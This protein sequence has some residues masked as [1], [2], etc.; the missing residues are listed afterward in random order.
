MIPLSSWVFF[1]GLL[2][3]LAAESELKRTSH[4]V[5]TS[6]TGRAFFTLLI[7]LHLP[8]MIM[9]Y[10]FYADWLFHYTLDATQLPSAI[11]IFFVFCSA[12]VGL[13]GFGLGTQWVRY[14][15]KG[16][17][18]TALAAVV[19]LNVVLGMVLRKRWMSVATTLSFSK[20][21]GIL[22]IFKT[23]LAIYLLIYFIMMA[24]Q[25]GWIILRVTKQ[26]TA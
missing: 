16:H 3:S 20:H 25:L 5:L 2:A 8:A 19:G 17:L 7:C 4:S 9:L 13:F 24:G 12:L 10:L 23:P 18:Y 15:T 22:S 6:V 21:F 14:E 26:K 11:A 1:L